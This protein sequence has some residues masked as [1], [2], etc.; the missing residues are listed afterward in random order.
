MS[1]QDFLLE[2]GC[3]E[4]PQHSQLPLAQQLADQL[5]TLLNEARITYSKAQVFATPRR[6]A[7]LIKHMAEKQITESI[8][9]LGPSIEHAYDKQGIPTLACMGFASACG[10]S[11]DQL[12]IIDTNKGQRIGAT[13]EQ[14]G[15]N[16][17]DIL[18]SL[19]Q[20]AFS[21]LSLVKPMHWGNE[22][23]SFIRP[24]HWALM[25]LGKTVIPTTLFNHTTSNETRGH[26]F[27]YPK[28]L[29]IHEPKDYCAQLYAQGSV[30]AN[31]EDRKKT[32]LKQINRY[33]T[34]QSQTIL[35]HHLLDEVTALVEW[36]VTLQGQ[37]KPEFLALPKEVLITS[38]QSHQK[39]FAMENSQ[40]QLLSSFI[41]VSNIESPTP[42][43]IIQGNE[44][45]INAR[46]SDAMFFF[47]NDLQHSLQSRSKQLCHVIFQEKLGTLK[48]KISR[49][50]KLTTFLSKT[51]DANPA[52]TKRAAQL[53]KSD[54]VSEMVVEFPSLQGIMGNYY[55]LHDGEEPLCAT[56]IQEH[57][58]PRFSKDGL[59]HS[60]EGATLAIADRL[61]TMT[62]ILG[63]NQTPT[64]DKDPYALRRSALG[65]LRIIIEQGYSIDLMTAI[66]KAAKGYDDL[67][68]TDVVTQTFDFIMMRF[69]AWY[70]E[71]GLGAPLFAA[72]SANTI[73]TPYE[74][75][76]RM[77][78]V[79]H[80]QTLPEAPILSQANKRVN[81]LLKKQASAL[82]KQALDTTLLHEPAEKALAEAIKKHETAIQPLL[83]CANYTE[84]LTQLA[85]LAT[86]VDDFF[87][88]V[89]VMDE[90]TTIRDNRLRLLGLLQAL[91]LQVADIA[92]LPT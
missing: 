17:Q 8:Q 92:L 44:R 29:R 87:E 27:H 6:I 30:I 12:E 72:V 36:P 81:N 67:P 10:I 89:M 21:Q 52:I 28:P 91:F 46:L 64:G 3:E 39:C 61:D 9:R 83:A 74:F 7:V 63:I 68:N 65:I 43:I 19:V 37:F 33:N 5:S 13:I 38:M 58:Q 35:D 79:E 47:N 54:L 16:T 86:P 66:E 14:A 31:F 20:Q 76:L 50:T 40:H 90:N 55:A 34:D 2:L 32:I 77:K 57:Y 23:F 75:H 18:P 82:K 15:K 53:C 84:A 60:H 78:A 1:N 73:T 42:D 51:T 80:F 56:A 45:V 59:P 71:Q 85:A 4:L 41:L 25:L 49:L 88:N 26:R 48:D 70:Q 24:V 69:K 22:T 11:A 62:G